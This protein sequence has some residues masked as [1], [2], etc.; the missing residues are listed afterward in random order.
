MTSR[1][2][3]PLRPPG[4]HLPTAAMRR[5]ERDLSLR[6]APSRQEHFG[7]HQMIIAEPGG[8]D[9]HGLCTVD[10]LGPPRVWTTAERVG[11]G[12]HE[13]PPADPRSLVR[14]YVHRTGGRPPRAK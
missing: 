13:Q 5:R 4:E 9:G 11:A 14:A 12:R 10:N 2:T 6:T 1:A 7:C 8:E 3:T